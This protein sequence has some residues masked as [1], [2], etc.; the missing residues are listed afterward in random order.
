MVV[1]ILFSWWNKT[2]ST[3]AFV[4]ITNYI[5]LISFN[6]SS[7]GAATAHKGVFVL[8]FEEAMLFGYGSD[9]IHFLF[10]KWMN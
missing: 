6:L 4:N 3:S 7:D 1:Y 8:D 5:F 2:H 9:S 10:L